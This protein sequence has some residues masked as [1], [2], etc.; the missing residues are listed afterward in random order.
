MTKILVD[1]NN[2]VF[3]IDHRNMGE[4]LLF[5][6]VPDPEYHEGKVGILYLNPTSNQLYYVYVDRPPTPE[7]ELQQLKEKQA[8]M[9]QAID[10]LIFG[11]AL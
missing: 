6:N 1:A 2:R 8:L 10:E 11:G 4:G 7:E 5:E 9:Q 3:S